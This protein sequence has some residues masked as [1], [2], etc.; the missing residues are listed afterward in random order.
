MMG[1]LAFKNGHN[2]PFFRGRLALTCAAFG[3]SVSYDILLSLGGTKTA[4]LCFEE[5]MLTVTFS[6]SF[7]SFISALEALYD[8]FDLSESD[9]A[10]FTLQAPLPV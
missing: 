4:R 1:R 8:Q 7:D 5:Q 9:L 2:N 6:I 10:V 3:D